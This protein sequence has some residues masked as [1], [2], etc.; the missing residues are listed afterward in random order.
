[1]ALIEWKSEYSIGVEEIDLNHKRLF[2]MIGQFV[3]SLSESHM[4]RLSATIL[5]PLV[6]HIKT[7]FA[8]EEKIMLRIKF[9]DYK[10]HRLLHESFLKNIAAVLVRIKKGKQVNL[11]EPMEI[12]S[13]LMAAHIMK[14]DK[15]IARAYAICA[16]AETIL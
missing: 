3:D 10:R 12:F 7:I 2:D 9:P 11:L 1:M 5:M 13:E 8:E 15:K 16:E 14:E 6:I 4:T